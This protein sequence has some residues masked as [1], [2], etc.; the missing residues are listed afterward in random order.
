MFIIALFRIARIWKQPVSIDAS[1]EK[2][3]HEY[4]I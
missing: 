1:I 2:L 4:T 3:G